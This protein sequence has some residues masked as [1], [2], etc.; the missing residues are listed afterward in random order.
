MIV[1]RHLHR[2]PERPG[3][4]HRHRPQHGHGLRHEPAGPRQLPRKRIASPFLVGGG[5]DWPRAHA[6]ASKPPAKST[7]KCKRIIDESMEKVRHILEAR[8]AS[9]RS[10]RQTADRTRSDRRRRTETDHRRKLPQPADRPRHRRRPQTPHPAG[11]GSPAAARNGGRVA[12]TILWPEF[13]CQFWFHKPPLAPG[14]AG[15]L[16]GTLGR[17]HRMALQPPGKAGG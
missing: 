11:R 7:R 15:G 2:R 16:W 12:V 4:G 1:R 3:T 6:T 10:A 8:K 13:L 17:R 14:S 5:G 9:L